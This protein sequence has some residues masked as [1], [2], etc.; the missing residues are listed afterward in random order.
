[1]QVLQA[2]VRRGRLTVDAASELPEGTAVELT[3][4]STEERD[5]LCGAHEDSD[6]V[7]ETARADP[8][9]KRALSKRLQRCPVC[10][11]RISTRACACPKCGHPTA[12]AER[13]WRTMGRAAMIWVVLIVL[14]LVAWQFIAPR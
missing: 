4:L 11:R 7:A 2:H 12:R 13:P 14:N 3:L 6:D 9:G 10:G 5:A 1:M 8:A